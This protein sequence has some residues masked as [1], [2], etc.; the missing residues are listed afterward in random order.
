MKSLALESRKGT[1][2]GGSSVR[3]KSA[4]PLGQ[5]KRLCREADSQKE[6]TYKS[7]H[8]PVND[9]TTC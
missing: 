3:W 6:A 5:S 2:V 7:F 9:I 4:R 1:H 8:E